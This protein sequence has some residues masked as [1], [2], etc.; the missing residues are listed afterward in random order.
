MPQ[1]LANIYIGPENDPLFSQ[2]P[3]YI[4]IGPKL[5]MLNLK[6]SNQISPDTS[7]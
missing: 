4:Y 5:L 1:M 6:E 7:K 2:V 3:E